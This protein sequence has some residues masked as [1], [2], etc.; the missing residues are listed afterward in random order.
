MSSD[1]AAHI[2]KAR[3]LVVLAKFSNGSVVRLFEA[4]RGS[5]KIVVSQGFRHKK[6]AP[7]TRSYADLRFALP[8]RGAD[9]AERIGRVLVSLRGVTQCALEGPL[10]NRRKLIALLGPDAAPHEETFAWR[11]AILDPVDL[12][13]VITRTPGGGILTIEEALD[14]LAHFR[15]REINRYLS[16]LDR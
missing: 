14:P 7:G 2:S 3:S 12:S 10:V 1:D 13:L 15:A 11:D 8:V 6:L 4:E 5:V 16:G 9:S